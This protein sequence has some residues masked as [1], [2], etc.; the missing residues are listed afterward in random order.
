MERGILSTRDIEWLLSSL[1]QLHR[2]PFDAGLLRG[3]C[4]P[5]HNLA[6][7]LMALDGMGHKIQP[8]RLDAKPLAATAL[9]F[10]A[11]E[12]AIPHPDGDGLT[13]HPALI[14]GAGNDTYVIN[15]GD[16]YDTVPDTDGTGTLIFNGLT[17]SGGNLVAGTT[18][19]WKNKDQGI[20]YTLKGNYGAGVPY[21]DDYLSG[22]EGN[23]WLY[24]TGGTT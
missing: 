12:K 19:V 20:T 23:D 4:P 16:G 1:C 5:P 13:G 14:G 3:Q 9:P 15:A 21:D 11:F 17:L 22:G 6:Q 8:A 10:I 7:L 18:N 24:G 2:I